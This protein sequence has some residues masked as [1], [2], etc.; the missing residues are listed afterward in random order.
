MHI[1][2][3]SVSIRIVII[4]ELH[5]YVQ[6]ML[7]CVAIFTNMTINEIKKC[8]FLSKIHFRN[9]AFK[10]VIF[11]KIKLIKLLFYFKYFNISIFLCSFSFLFTF[12][13]S[14][15]SNMSQY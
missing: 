13:F 14:N 10:V 11:L 2:Y 8:L 7:K 1:M 15:I 3:K 4:V 12:Q 9:A 6:K 5:Y